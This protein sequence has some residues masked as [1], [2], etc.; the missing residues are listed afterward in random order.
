MKEDLRPR[1]VRFA[2]Q[3]LFQAFKSLSTGRS[4]ER[5]L[6]QSLTKAIEDLKQNPQCG[7]KVPRQLWPKEYIRD[8]GIDNL[9]KIDLPDAWRLMYTLV[10]NE[11]EIV[12]VLL[13]WLSHKEYERRFGYKSK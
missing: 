11:V 3:K 7:V 10:G 4:E 5:R 12:S 8:Y 13:E 6:A 2:D 1:K 9:R